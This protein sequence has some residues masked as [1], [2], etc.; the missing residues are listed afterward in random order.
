VPALPRELLCSFRHWSGRAQHRS[1]LPRT[2]GLT[3]VHH[4]RDGYAP[5]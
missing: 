5:R 2:R 3:I 1:G 4:D